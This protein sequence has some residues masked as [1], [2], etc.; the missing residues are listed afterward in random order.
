LDIVSNTFKTKG[1][2]EFDEHLCKQIRID[3]IEHKENLD[4]LKI[5]L[6]E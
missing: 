1:G 3:I 4:S 2:K 5:E 6:G